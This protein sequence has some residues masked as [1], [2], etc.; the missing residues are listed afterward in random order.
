MTETKY[1]SGR[2]LV[3]EGKADEFV[4]RWTQWI[5]E[6]TQDA[7]GFRSA[8]LLR[9]QGDSLRFTSISEWVDDP[10]LKAWKASPSFREHLASMKSLCDDFLGGDYDVASSFSAP[11]VPA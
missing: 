7:P 2:W 8:A 1:A 3:T 10:S 4:D 6:A 5:S 11:A 9:S